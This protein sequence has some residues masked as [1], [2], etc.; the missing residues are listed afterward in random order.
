MI[1]GV[2]KY[3]TYR[4]KPTDEMIRIKNEYMKRENSILQFLDSCICKTGCDEDFVCSRDLYN[5]YKQFCESN[6]M[7]EVNSAK[8]FKSEAICGLNK[9][10]TAKDRGYR[11]ISIV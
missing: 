2:N 1:D 4:L 10:R 3:T 11:G 6:G 7:K 5:S 9:V 8:F